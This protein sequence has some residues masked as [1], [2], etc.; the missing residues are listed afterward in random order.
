MHTFHPVS[1]SAD[2]VHIHG[3]GQNE[4][5][6]N[7]ISLQISPVFPL[8]LFQDPADDITLHLAPSFSKTTYYLAV[9]GLSRGTVFAVSRGASPC[10]ARP[11]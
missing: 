2:V 10:S 9:L 5:L 6:N 1:S 11:L 3:T 7:G 4:E 8:L